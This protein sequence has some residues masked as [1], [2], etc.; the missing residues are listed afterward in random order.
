GS[1]G[2]DEIKRA[3]EGVWLSDGRTPPM[4]VRVL[5][6]GREI[7]TA[8]CTLVERNHHQLKRIWA[9]LGTPVIKMVLVRIATVGTEDLKKGAVPPL[10]PDE[11]AELRSGAP[12][13]QVDWSARKRRVEVPAEEEGPVEWGA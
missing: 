8:K 1:V 7:S 10:K 11:V 6:A 12:G 5:R 13:P 4:E 2:L 9:R 3:R